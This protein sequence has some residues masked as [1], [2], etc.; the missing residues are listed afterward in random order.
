MRPERAGVKASMAAAWFLAGSCVS[1]LPSPAQAQQV[2]ADI[3]QATRFVCAV[4]PRPPAGW[5]AGV[6][7]YIQTW[8]NRCG[9]PEISGFYFKVTFRDESGNPPAGTVLVQ[10]IQSDLVARITTPQSTDCGDEE[11]GPMGSWDVEQFPA[12]PV[13]DY[14][15]IMG[16][17]EQEGRITR[18]AQLAFLPRPAGSQPPQQGEVAGAAYTTEAQRATAGNDVTRNRTFN[19]AFQFEF[20]GCDFNKARGGASY[21]EFWTQPQLPVGN[22]NNFSL[23]PVEY[24]EER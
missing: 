23:A 2:V 4:P 14:H 8:Q 22:P 16:C 20:D 1:A 21:I 6:S 18:T 11:M 5:P 9:R 24:R 15:A 12:Y 3:E 19:W 17:C 13:E 7:D 10:R